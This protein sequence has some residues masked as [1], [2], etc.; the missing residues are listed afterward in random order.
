MAYVLVLLFLAL[1]YVCCHRRLFLRGLSKPPFPPSPDSFPFIGNLLDI[2]TQNEIQ[3]YHQWARKFGAIMSV[4]VF[5]RSVIYLNS[6]A[7]AKDIF[8]KRSSNYSERTKLHM[9]N[10]LMGWDWSFAMHPNDKYWRKCRKCVH[11]QFQPSS[12]RLFHPTHIRHAHAL[13]RRMVDSPQDLEGNLRH[14]AAAT[15]MGVAYGIQIADSGDRYVRAAEEALQSVAIAGTPGA[16]LVD[17]LPILKYVPEWFPGASFKR[18]AREWKRLSYEMRDAPFNAVK[19]SLARG[20]ARPS[21]VTNH[22]EK[23]AAESQK[24]NKSS[25]AEQEKIIKGSAGTVYAAGNDSIVG[26][27][28]TFFLAMILHPAVQCKAQAELDDVL[29]M[30]N[31]ERRLPDYSDRSNLPYIDAVLKEVLRWAPV[32]PLGLPHMAKNDD[33][34]DGYLIPAGSL[35]VGFVW[36]MLHDPSVYTD[37]SSFSPERFLP[38]E[39]GRNPEPDPSQVAFGF[40]RRICPGRHM[41]S[42]A[43]WIAITSFLASF[44]I[45]PAINPDTGLEEEVKVGFTSGLVCHP[46]PFTYRITPRSENAVAH[47]RQTADFES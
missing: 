44:D 31:G 32:A 21:F 4:T 33:T 3:V 17:I 7:A 11:D 13:L 14:Y 2:P 37:P 15:V 30:D 20:E 9:I 29:V 16:F 45:S 41:G 25:I 47:I 5:G 46:L 10:D 27:L 8:E 26:T 22:L 24:I 39:D 34:Y 38:K 19:A 43:L 35:I 18:K 1:I 36:E 12:A 23:L 6:I 28:H 40:G 42:A